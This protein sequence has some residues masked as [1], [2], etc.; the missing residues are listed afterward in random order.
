[1]ADSSSSSPLTAY[2]IVSAAAAA[3]GT[4]GG[5]DP[6]R[7]VMGRVPGRSAFFSGLAAG[8]PL[9]T[10]LAALRR[11]LSTC[12]PDS[13]SLADQCA[14]VADLALILSV[15][16]T[17]ANKE[18]TQLFLELPPS[19][20][21]V[22]SHWNGAVPSSEGIFRS[23][24]VLLNAAAASHVMR[25]DP[26]VWRQTNALRLL[27][28]T[29]LS[30]PAAVARIHFSKQ[31]GDWKTAL[32][33]LLV[34]I[35]PSQWTEMDVSGT[36]QA[37]RRAAMPLGSSS[38]KECKDLL[39]VLC[40]QSTRVFR[41][42]NTHIAH[43]SSPSAL[44]NTL[45]I[46]ALDPTQ[47]QTACKVL[48]SATPS[49]GD[50]EEAGT[51]N[52]GV[53]RQHRVR[54]NHHTVYHIAQCF[55]RKWDVGLRLASQWIAR[56]SISVGS[57]PAAVA[58]L[59]Q[60]CIAGS[61][62]QEALHLMEASN[63]HS[64]ATPVARRQHLQMPLARLLSAHVPSGSLAPHFHTSSLNKALN[65][66]LQ[67]STTTQSAENFHSMLQRNRYSVEN[68]STAHLVSLYAKE[69]QWILAL[70]SLN[71]L[72]HQTRHSSQFTYT[73]LHDMVQYALEQA[74]AP[75]ASWEVSVK[76]FT[77][78]TSERR[79]PV[80]EVAFQSVIKKCFACGASKQAQQLFEY[81]IRHGVRRP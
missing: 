67:Q 40:Q 74:P 77:R 46:L 47:W 49:P 36:L 55:Q 12:S 73:A 68:D 11:A 56:D 26:H 72:L 53:S 20:E 14:A 25:S 62:W 54:G 81:L 1:M 51:P 3:A 27:L 39:A 65:V 61:R 15:E 71:H 69:G 35:A 10:L 79:T 9:S 57:D 32:E 59:L 29:P 6:G 78:M 70:S 22:L 31:A 16:D 41:M 33:S 24:P 45:A 13:P 18:A 66:L 4:G 2:S 50:A 48:E 7:G 17:A 23:L 28:E 44:N 30:P 80:S 19:R 5:E 52:G 64:P 37:C 43:W 76:L 38:T 60:L 63:R 34:G 42:A 21:R 58:S 8:E 75:G